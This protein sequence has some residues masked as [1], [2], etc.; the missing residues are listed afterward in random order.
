MDEGGGGREAVRDVA[1]ATSNISFVF[2]SEKDVFLVCN[3]FPADKVVALS[4]NAQEFRG[5]RISLFG[6]SL[7]A[8]HEKTGIL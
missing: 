6:K 5:A 3:G 2:S 8:G 1:G 7:P 4:L